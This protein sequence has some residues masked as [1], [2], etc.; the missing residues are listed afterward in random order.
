MGGIT[1][2]RYAIG[3]VLF[4]MVAL[5]VFAHFTASVNLEVT[6]WISLAGRLLLGSLAFIMLGFFLGYLAGPNSA[7]AVVR[8]FTI[9]GP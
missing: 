9:C 6:A 7:P 2:N 1:G 3:L 5:F 8:R 4:A